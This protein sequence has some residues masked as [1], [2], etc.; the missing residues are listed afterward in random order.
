M[1]PSFWAGF[2]RSSTPWPPA[3]NRLSMK[4]CLRLPTSSGACAVASRAQ[5]HHPNSNSMRQIIGRIGFR[6]QCG[7]GLGKTTTKLLSD[8][9]PIDYGDRIPN[10]LDI[11]DMNLWE[12]R[13]GLLARSNTERW[14]KPLPPTL[15]VTPKVIQQWRGEVWILSPQPVVNNFCAAKLL[16][17]EQLDFRLPKRRHAEL[18]RRITLPL[19]KDA[20]GETLAPSSVLWT[21]TNS[22]RSPI[23]RPSIRPS[24]V[25]SPA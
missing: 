9:K 10:E 8:T 1:S 2:I 7:S 15:I 16:T 18:G 25:Q 13:G 21:K 5:S 20:L 19:S 11:G 23:R 4:S 3:M 17:C 24:R 6:Q 22:Q 12:Q 14:K